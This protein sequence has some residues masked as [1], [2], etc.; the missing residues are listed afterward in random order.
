[1]IEVDAPERTESGTLQ[2][3]LD[4]VRYSPVPRRFWSPD[5]RSAPYS[6]HGFNTLLRPR[7]RAAHQVPAGHL[8]PAKCGTTL[9]SLCL[10]ILPEERRQTGVVGYPD[11]RA[12]GKNVP[13][14]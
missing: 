6:S 3:S 7:G 5:R 1:M 10:R 8:R 11:P 13:F 12:Q 4:S 9:L 2:A 14:G